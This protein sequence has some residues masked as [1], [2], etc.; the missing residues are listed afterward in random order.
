MQKIKNSVK[1]VAPLFVLSELVLGVLIQHLSGN[2]LSALS[3]SSVVLAFVF[4]L[5][6]CFAINTVSAALTAGGLLFT[7]V[8]DF[9]L[10]VM[11]PQLRLSA[12]ISFSVVQIC[13]FI[14][15]YR[16]EK[17]EKIKKANIYVRLALSVG[18]MIAAA[19]VLGD[20]CDALALISV[21]YF[22]NLFSNFLFS[23]PKKGG[24]PL[25]SIGLL[26]FILCDVTVGLSVMSEF[27]IP[28]SESSVIYKV[29]HADINLVWLFYVPS[30]TIIPLSLLSAKAVFFS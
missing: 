8:S 1:F 24:S 18:I 3:F 20:S 25:L 27:Y 17:S 30:Q 28:L 2:L 7:V 26:C 29:L 13:Y 6:I 12:M 15:I 10:V 23:L 19:L 4:S 14:R 11:S 16:E 22:A 9:F 21:F 5:Y